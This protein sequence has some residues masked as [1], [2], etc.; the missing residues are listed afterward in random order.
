MAQRQS[1]VPARRE[2]ADA[3]VS[4]EKQKERLQIIRE[5]AEASITQLDQYG[6]SLEAFVR[7]AQ[8]AWQKAASDTKSMIYAGT[9][10]S[11]R[12]AV[13]KSASYGLLLGEDCYL[14]KYGP[15][16]QC[17]PKY[18]GLLKIVRRGKVY[19]AITVAPVYENDRFVYKAGSNPYLEHEPEFGER[20][21]LRLVYLMA[22]HKDA[23]AGPPVIVTMHLEDVEK[24]RQAS[25]AKNNGKETPSWRQWYDEMALKCVVHYAVKRGMIEM[26]TEVQRIMSELRDSDPELG[27]AKEEGGRVTVFRQPKRLS[28]AGLV[29]EEVVIDVE[30]EESGETAAAGDEKPEDDGES[31]AA[32]PS[33][34]EQYD[35]SAGDFAILNKA[36]DQFGVDVEALAVEA[37]G[38]KRKFINLVTAAARAA[39]GEGGGE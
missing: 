10:T 29:D 17:V 21:K 37:G 35:L 13:Y 26:T 15:E 1:N 18:T 7:F 4:G 32:E 22:H 27:P 19:G 34:M 28:D 36:R 38:D 3:A 14:I 16:I 30:P 33:P 12:A 9:K 5:A 31:D 23:S 20:G 24:R 25:I 6:V 2:P 8:L 11:L 39:Q